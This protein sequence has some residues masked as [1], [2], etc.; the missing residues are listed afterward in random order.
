MITSLFPTICAESVPETVAFYREMLGFEVV[1][2]SNGYVLL[3]PPGQPSIRIGIVARDHDSIP[4]AHYDWPVGVLI[5][6]E[7][8]DV[9]EVYSKVVEAGA[10]VLRELRDEDYGQRHFITLDPEGTMVDV[11][12]RIAVPEYEGAYDRAAITCDAG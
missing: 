8:D 12:T 6:V 7:V 4:S 11:I 3:H 1:D 9:D 10:C 2:V 5:G